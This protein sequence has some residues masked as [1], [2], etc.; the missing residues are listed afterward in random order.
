MAITRN[1]ERKAHPHYG[2]LVSWDPKGSKKAGVK[3]ETKIEKGTASASTWHGKKADSLAQAEATGTT[4]KD[5]FRSLI[6][7]SLILIVELVV[8]L[9]WNKFF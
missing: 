3:G 2:F 9:A 5:I 1:R 6:I 7:I 4:K 8:Y